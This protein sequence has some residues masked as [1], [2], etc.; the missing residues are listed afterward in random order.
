MIFV[1]DSPLFAQVHAGL[2]ITFQSNG[3]RP[4]ICLGW[5]GHLSYREDAWRCGD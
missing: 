2:S 3:K 5:S 1:P 4:A